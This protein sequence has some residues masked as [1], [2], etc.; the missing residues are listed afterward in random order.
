LYFCVMY[1]RLCVF[2]AVVWMSSVF[3]SFR[4]AISCDWLSN[5]DRGYRYL[6]VFVICD[7]FSW[8]LIEC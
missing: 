6:F 3:S 1:V 8:I 4:L 2:L 5:C 7:L